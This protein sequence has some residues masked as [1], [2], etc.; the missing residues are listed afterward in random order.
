MYEF[1]KITE[2]E[3][4]EKIKNKD[5]DFSKY[6]FDFRI[7][8]KKE[9]EIDF[10]LNFSKS[11]FRDKVT[12]RKTKFRDNFFIANSVFE[13]EVDFFDSV[14]EDNFSA[15]NATFKNNTLF[16]MVKFYEDVDFNKTS[17]QST[18][19]FKKARFIKNVF[20]HKTKFYR[21]ADFSYAHFSND[22]ISSFISINENKELHNI[23][24]PPLFIFKNILFS[25]STVFNDVDLS[26]A[27]FQDSIIENIIFKECTFPKI[28]GRNSFYVE[29]P[30]KATLNI[31]GDFEKISN[32][33]INTIILGD[34]EDAAE[35]CLSDLIK[36]KDSETGKS[37]TFFVVTKFI[38][39]SLNEA[40]EKINK[41]NN[42]R[43][44]IGIKD[45]S[46]KVVNVDD[47]HDGKI[48]ALRVKKFV[49]EK[50]W[51][52]LEDLYRQMKKSLEDSHDWQMAGDFYKGEMNAKM[53]LLR[54]RKEQSGYRVML[55]IYKLISYFG[56][57]ITRI[58]LIVFVSGF[59]GTLIL[60]SFKPES[61]ILDVIS[62]NISLYMPIFGSNTITIET[63]QLTSFQEIV[64]YAEVAWFY[65]MWLILAIATRRRFRR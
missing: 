52:V 47:S 31:D 8:F 16:N 54:V 12:F 44:Y 63:L 15:N 24:Y 19:Y 64:I 10:E 62:T 13:K 51:E 61:S 22:N 39:D 50:H 43:Y 26:R 35:M 58:L 49:P 2:R 48:I 30:E 14:F 3:F 34:N 41:I 6:E 5:G 36:I 46:M 56:E 11:I 55:W 65:F 7:D 23:K 60:K 38:F 21:K 27:V 57:S 59:F 25:S 33:E 1:Q 17:F 37:E 45:M 4:W 18:V 32:E 20:F 9:S 29:K 42:K 28:D 53:N 40:T